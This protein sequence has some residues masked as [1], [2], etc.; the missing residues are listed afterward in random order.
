MKKRTI[1]IALSAIIL[2]A[3]FGLAGTGAASAE[4]VMK[5]CGDQWKQAKASG[6][7]NGMT[8]K[9]FLAQCREQQKGA[10]PA[11]AAA[12]PAAA[13][14]APAPVVTAAAGG[15]TAKECNA[16]YAANK[17]AIKASGQKKKD[18]VEA[19]RAGT[20]TVPPG[21]APAAAA[22]APAAAPPPAAPPPAAAQAPKP[23]AAK[24][25]PAAAAPAAGEFQTEA[26]AKGKCPTDTVVWVNTKSG[27]YHFAGTRNYGKTKH[28]AYM[29]EADA[30]AAGRRA[31]EEEK[32]P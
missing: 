8:W 14:A 20:E 32:H 23:T 9:D 11:A 24:P 25:K 22:P 15:K 26:E 12:A 5:I 27:V 6:S 29:C 17:E 19:C 7:T 28:G 10:A 4:S 2:A 3:A 13:P 30:K 31:S 21:A 1:G 16:E 18:F